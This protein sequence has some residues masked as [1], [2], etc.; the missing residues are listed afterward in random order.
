MSRV[1]G[2]QSVNEVDLLQCVMHSFIVD[3]CREIILLVS[4]RT[5]LA[6][7]VREVKIPSGVKKNLLTSQYM[8]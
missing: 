7:L 2:Y 3:F 5:M 4:G 8:R 1:L 6:I